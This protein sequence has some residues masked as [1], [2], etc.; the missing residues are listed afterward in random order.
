[1]LEAGVDAIGCRRAIARYTRLDQ[2]ATE[3]HPVFQLAPAQQHGCFT[4]DT[5][6]APH[7]VLGGDPSQC[8]PSLISERIILGHGHLL[9]ANASRP[10]RKLIA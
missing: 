8:R 5:A 2:Q 9:Q 3:P 10:N 6:D 1:V 4:T 7:P